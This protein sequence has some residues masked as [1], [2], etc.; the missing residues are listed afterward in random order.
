MELINKIEGHVLR[1]YTKPLAGDIHVKA[2]CLPEMKDLPYSVEVRVK[3]T[4]ARIQCAQC[5][6]PA[7]R[8][9]QGF[10]QTLQHCVG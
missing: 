4:D 8:A 3:K 10:L 7:G 1:I 9:P 2:M 5:G 6:C